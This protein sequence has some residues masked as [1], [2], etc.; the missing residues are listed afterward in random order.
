MEDSKFRAAGLTL[1][2]L[3]A[4]LCSPCWSGV[5]FSQSGLANPGIGNPVGPATVPQSGVQSGLVRSPNPIDSGGSLGNMIITG[6]VQAGK[7]FRGM[8][9][10]RSTTDFRAAWLD[11]ARLVLE[12]F[13]RL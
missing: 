4:A 7:H 10:Y 8:V 1:A 5:G 6:N 12:V 3:L 2:M 11:F 9:P 13:S